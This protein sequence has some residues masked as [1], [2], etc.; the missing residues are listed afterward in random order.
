MARGNSS[1]TPLFKAAVNSVKRENYKSKQEYRS[2]KTAAIKDASR[3]YRQEHP[4]AGKHF[5]R[6]SADGLN[7]QQFVKQQ[8][9]ASV[10]A[11]SGRLSKTDMRGYMKKAA[12]A[13]DQLKRLDVVDT[14]EVP[15]SEIRR[16][17]VARYTNQGCPS[18]WAIRGKFK[19]IKDENGNV[20]KFKKCAKKGQVR[21]LHNMGHDLEKAKLSRAIKSVSSVV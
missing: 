13:W 12:K 17:R 21:M 18:G 5:E 14:V 8:L 19:K 9:K 3:Q 4:N 10:N 1:W 7:Y 20:L 11:H 6:H 16:R 15:L 2:A